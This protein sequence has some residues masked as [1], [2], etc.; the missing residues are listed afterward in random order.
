VID[1]VPSPVLIEPHFPSGGKRLFR[2]WLGAVVGRAAA[3]G[4][5]GFSTSAISG[6]DSTATDK[7]IALISFLNMKINIIITHTG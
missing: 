6:T 7:V 5:D 4:L 1:V 2:N 3:R